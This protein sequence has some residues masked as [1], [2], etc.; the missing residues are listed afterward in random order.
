[1]SRRKAREMALQAL[2]QLDFNA[3]EKDVALQSVFAEREA[4]SEKT[5]S[6]AELLVK[7]TIANIEAID[8]T[9]NNISNEWKLDRMA[10]VDRNIVRLAIFELHYSEENLPPNVIINE[11]VELA[12]AFGTED[13][14]RFV[15]GL[16]GSLIKNKI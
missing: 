16:L 10:G 2:F 1:M 3:V 15:N 12:K 13:S 6:Y 5:Q 7:G 14:G 8:D 9:I 11:A 4:Q